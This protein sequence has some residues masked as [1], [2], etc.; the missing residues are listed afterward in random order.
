MMFW[1]HDTGVH[2][3]LAFWQKLKEKE[4]ISFKQFWSAWAIQVTESSVMKSEVVK[5]DSRSLGTGNGLTR[6]TEVMEG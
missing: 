1:R 5:D 6:M 3:N 2:S 4:E